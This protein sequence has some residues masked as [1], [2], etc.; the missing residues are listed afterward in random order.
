MSLMHF[1]YDPFSEF[2]RL[3]DDAFSSRFLRPSTGPSTETGRDIFR[4]R[5][6]VN[7]PCI[8]CV[9]SLTSMNAEWMCTRMLRTIQSP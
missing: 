4:P 5:Y 8:L 9:P 1:Y 3:F 7:G 2:E 6:V